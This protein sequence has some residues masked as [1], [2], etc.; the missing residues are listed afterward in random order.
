MPIRRLLVGMAITLWMVACSRT[1]LPVSRDATVETRPSAETGANTDHVPANPDSTTLAPDVSVPDAAAGDAV[2]RDAAVA[3]A[4]VPD[5]GAGDAAVADTTVP[6]AGAGDA[7]VADAGDVLAHDVAISDVAPADTAASD[8]RE[9]AAADTTAPAD[10]MEA[11][12]NPFAGRSFRIDDTNP[13]PT[14]D[15]TCTPNGPVAS[16]YFT[17]SSDLTSLTGTA[18]QGSTAWRFDAIVGPESNKLTYHVTN[19]MGGRVYLEGDQGVYVA[20]VVLY[21]SGVPVMWCL[22][23][24]LT[25]QP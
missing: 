16:A 17:F 20:Q 23:G 2:A 5:A 1:S 12:P 13:A 9:T 3:D 15:P 22:R 4:I 24:A 6:E 21:G 14:P 10:V 25:P 8:M 11:A 19:L 18:S 7:A